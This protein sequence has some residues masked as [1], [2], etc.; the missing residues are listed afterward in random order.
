MG[1][2]NIHKFSLGFQLL[3]YTGSLFHSLYYRR[4]KVA[5][6]KRVPRD[7]PVIFASNHQ[8]GLMDPLAVIFALH[9]PIVYFA[10]ADIFKKKMVARM[11]YFLKI[12][13][14]YRPRDGFRSVEKNR[15]MFGEA[16]EVLQKG[17]A[18]GILPEGNHVGQKHLRPLRK[19]TARMAF[20]AEEA[21]GFSL[22]LC[23]VPAGI[24]YSEY[25]RAGSDLL[26]VMGEPLPVSRYKEL[27]LENAPRAIAQLT[28]DLAESLKKVMLHIEPQEAYDTI[29]AAAE[30]SFRAIMKKKRIKPGLYQEFMLKQKLI[31][32]LKDLF[33]KDDERAIGLKEM[34][35]EYLNRLHSLKL[36]DSIIRKGNR[37]FLRVFT[38][39]F[40][41]TLLLPL[42][43]YGAI[44]NIIPFLL[45]SR[46]ARLVRDPHLKISVSFGAALFIFIL[47]YLLY[48][49]VSLFIPVPPFLKTIF[50]M[51]LPL[52]GWFS[53]YYYK[54]FLKMKG[55][56]RLLLLK[57]RNRSE[58]EQIFS[59]KEKII[60]ISFE[61]T[62]DKLT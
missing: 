55:K 20:Q 26:I 39:A 21:S 61:S 40:L 12:L 13:P 60:D 37:P 18:I 23:I 9:R 17:K 38:Q 28:S 27:Y 22:G 54:F 16:V 7:R 4:K 49:L 34:I 32:G 25:F 58:F 53:F 50:L 5:G 45:P 8:N 42:F 43:L 62:N 31:G 15:E 1:R 14:V 33:L 56:W 47:W 19:G 51:S 48:V 30:I 2:K 59:L 6:K 44:T 24:D 29:H 36:E 35:T 11:L 10:R 3:L 46:L 52:S 41:M 57:W